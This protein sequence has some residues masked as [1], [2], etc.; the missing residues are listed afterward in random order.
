[1]GTSRGMLPSELAGT[2]SARAAHAPDARI[3]NGW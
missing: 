1:V 2:A 3:R